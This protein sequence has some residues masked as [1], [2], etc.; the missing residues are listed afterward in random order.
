MVPEDESPLAR[1]IIG[2][3]EDPG[4]GALRQVP[5]IQNGDRA[6]RSRLPELDEKL[7]KKRTGIKEEYVF[8]LIQKKGRHKRM[9]VYYFNKKK[10]VEDRSMKFAASPHLWAALE[11]ALQLEK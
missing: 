6:Y 10:N 4:A 1:Q 8:I 11:W 7:E 3:I 5:A 9:D 2:K